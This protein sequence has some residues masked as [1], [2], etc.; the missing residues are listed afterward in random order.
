[1][2]LFIARSNPAGK[3]TIK[4]SNSRDFSGLLC[5]LT[6][7]C[8]LRPLEQLETSGDSSNI[9]ASFQIYSN[10]K[11][12]KLKFQISFHA[13]GFDKKYDCDEI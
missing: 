2:E 1:M 3:K 13:S 6:K 7:R 8:N 12:K 10:P 5:Q 9:E 11:Q 4:L